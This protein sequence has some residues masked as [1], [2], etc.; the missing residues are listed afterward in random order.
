M[1]YI[2]INATVSILESLE[3][4]MGRFC[5]TSGIKQNCKLLAQPTA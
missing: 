4:E 3:D 1:S 2:A 5:A